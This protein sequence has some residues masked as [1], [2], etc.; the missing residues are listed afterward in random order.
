[1]LKKS[2]PILLVIAALALA[3]PMVVAAQSGPPDTAQRLGMATAA[4]GSPAASP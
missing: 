2:L 1:M 4:A 3:L